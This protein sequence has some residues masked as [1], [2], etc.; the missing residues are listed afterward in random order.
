MEF[1]EVSRSR[2]GIISGSRLRVWNIL[3]PAVVLRDATFGTRPYQRKACVFPL[4]SSRPAFSTIRVNQ[5]PEVQT[6]PSKLRHVGDTPKE[7]AS[8]HSVFPRPSL[9][10]RTEYAIARNFFARCEQNV[11]S[12]KR[13]FLGTS[14]SCLDQVAG[15]VACRSF[16]RG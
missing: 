6:A 9:F 10:R 14:L 12:P 4:Q 16:E 5:V 1:K 11:S 3:R 7:N 2:V 13:P 8:C 15:A